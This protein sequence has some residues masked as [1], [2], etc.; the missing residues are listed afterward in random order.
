MF[1]KFENIVVPVLC[2][3]IIIGILCTMIFCD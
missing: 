1:E 3:T 2:V